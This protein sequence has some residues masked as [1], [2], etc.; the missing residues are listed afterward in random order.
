MIL[1][2]VHWRTEGGNSNGFTWFRTRRA[3]KAEMEKV[4]DRDALIDSDLPEVERVEVE[5][6]A[7]GVFAALHVYASHPDN[8]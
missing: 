4:I 1:W 2:R 6:S 5:V 8:G 7:E 3:A